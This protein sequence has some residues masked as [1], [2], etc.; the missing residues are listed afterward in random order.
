MNVFII[1]TAIIGLALLLRWLNRPWR[2]CYS[3]GMPKTPKKTGSGWY[4][5]FPTDPKRHVHYVQWFKPP[6]LPL[7]RTL[8]AKFAVTG[9]GF[10]AQ[11]Y[12]ANPASVTLLIQRK[13]DNGS[14]EGKYESYRMYSNTMQVLAAGTFELEILLDSSAWGGVYGGHDPAQF[15]ATLQNVGSIGLVF[16]S[17]GGRGHGV[18]ATQPSRFTLT[19]FGVR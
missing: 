6:P 15:A 16:G 5:D 19:E 4:F 10:I 17:A 11:Q 13:G 18:Y 9:S 14:A 8:Y 1:V 12:P 2:I 7:G 3:P